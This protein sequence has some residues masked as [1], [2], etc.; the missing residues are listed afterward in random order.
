MFFASC[1]LHTLPAEIE[2]C[3]AEDD[4][5][6][7]SDSILEPAFCSLN[8]IPELIS[9]ILEREPKSKLATAQQRVVVPL[10]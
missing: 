6:N 10:Q 2:K 7:A 1:N 4:K 9:H 3:T 8:F 5:D